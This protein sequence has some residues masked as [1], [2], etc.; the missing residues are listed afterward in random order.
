MVEIVPLAPFYHRLFSFILLTSLKIVLTLK[1][2]KMNTDNMNLYYSE[3]SKNGELV[4]KEAGLT[5]VPKHVV[6]S[7]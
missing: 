1:R 3:L 7:I 5:E 2:I 6:E 4:L